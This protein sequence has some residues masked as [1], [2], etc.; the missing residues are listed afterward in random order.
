[1]GIIQIA[2]GLALAGTVLVLL[3]GLFSLARGGA[4]NAR[5]GNLLMRLRVIVQGVA[6]VTMAGAMVL[7]TYGHFGNG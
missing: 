6:V 5:Y 7:M 2:V 3:L 1:M 4:F